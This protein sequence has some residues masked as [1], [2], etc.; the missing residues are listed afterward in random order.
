M[1]TQDDNIQVDFRELRENPRVT[2]ASVKGDLDSYTSK[3]FQQVMSQHIQ[4]GLIRLIIDCSELD[5]VSS[6]GLGSL[7]VIS[8]QVGKE[9]FVVFCN[10]R[11]DVVHVFEMVGASTIFTICDTY[12][13]S[14][15]KALDLLDHER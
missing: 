8:E 15:G 14:V 7:L 4:R 6:A 13:E 5:Y 2:V 10:L 12:E 1:D 3:R 9:G 11:D